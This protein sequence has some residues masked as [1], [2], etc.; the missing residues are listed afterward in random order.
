MGKEY[1]AEEVGNDTNFITI[2]A[3]F[4]GSSFVRLYS[5]N[6]TKRA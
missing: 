6:I 3:C 2:R 4:D 1:G 5:A